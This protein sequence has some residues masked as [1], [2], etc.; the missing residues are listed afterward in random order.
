MSNYQ[1]CI[2]IWYIHDLVYDLHYLIWL[3][4]AEGA[5]VI[6]AKLLKESHILTNILIYSDRATA[7]A[8]ISL[9][10]KTSL[11]CKFYFLKIFFKTV[12]ITSNSLLHTIKN[13]CS[14]LYICNII[15]FMKSAFFSFFFFV[16][17]ST[18]S[19][20]FSKVWCIRGQRYI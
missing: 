3:R 10:H 15:F 8:T 5:S 7:Y 18:I 6:V 14:I 12:L 19:C 17:S 11:I 16:F 2:L 4:R 13:F 9:N 20:L 1:L